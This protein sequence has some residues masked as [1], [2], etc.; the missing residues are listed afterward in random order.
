MKPI[1]ELMK[2][3]IR[4]SGSAPIHNCILYLNNQKENSNYKAAFG[5]MNA[6]GGNVNHNYCFRTGSITKTFTATIIM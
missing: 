6:S 5:Q 1:E 3:L 2:L 4:N